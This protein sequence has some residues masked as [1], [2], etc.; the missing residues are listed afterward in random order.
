MID[1]KYTLFL[2]ARQLSGFFYVFFLKRHN[3]F[4]KINQLKMYHG[5]SID[6]Y[7]NVFGQIHMYKYELG[8]VYPYETNEKL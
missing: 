5:K 6:V 1:T 4:F 7:F 3:N 2:E 8:Y